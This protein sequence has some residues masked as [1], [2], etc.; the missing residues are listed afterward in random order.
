MDKICFLAMT[1]VILLA[2]VIVLIVILK[3]GKFTFS[4]KRDKKEDAL[5]LE[6]EHQSHKDLDKWFCRSFGSYFF[7]NKQFKRTSSYY[8]LLINIYNNYSFVSI[9]ITNFMKL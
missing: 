3:D 7:N 4:F 9:V 2:L 5:C 8:F 6:T 1:I